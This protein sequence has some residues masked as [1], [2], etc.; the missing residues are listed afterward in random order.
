MSFLC[1]GTTWLF[2]VL[3][4]LSMTVGP[5]SAADQKRA[6]ENRLGMTFV[7]IPAGTFVMGSP[8]EEAHRDISEVQHPVT[9]S[10]PF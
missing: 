10:E 7:L 9:I 1:R 2:G 4:A 3:V 6:V 8:I 5:L